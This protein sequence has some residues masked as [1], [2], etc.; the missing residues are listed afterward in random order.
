MIRREHLQSTIIAIIIIL[1]GDGSGWLTRK[2][3]S[4][5]R[6]LMLMVGT[7]WRVSSM[8]DPGMP[9]RHVAAKMEALCPK[10]DVSQNLGTPYRTKNLLINRF[11]R[12]A[13]KTIKDLNTHS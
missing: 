4:P 6:Y 8:D 7:H 13:H 10:F 3:F 11:S 5:Q 1:E 9:R 2:L 12:S